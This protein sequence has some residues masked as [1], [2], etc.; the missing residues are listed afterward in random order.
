VRRSR[1]AGLLVDTNLLIYAF[2]PE[3]PEHPVARDW[4]T[5]ILIEGE[6]LLLTSAALVSFARL[7]TSSRI[8]RRP[9]G[10]DEALAFIDSLRSGP[11]TEQAEPG[12]GYAEI[13]T[14][15]CSEGELRGNDIPDAH[16]AAVAIEHGALLATHDRGFERFP[17]LRTVDPLA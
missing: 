8:V 14:R 15:I 1:K 13:F 2:R 4:L 6:R 7:A 16:L 5:R 3:S 17:D 11:G 12:P 9:V 10:V